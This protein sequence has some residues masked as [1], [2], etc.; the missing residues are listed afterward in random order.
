MHDDRHPHPDADNE[1]V[2]RSREGD[3][4][5]FE[6]LVRRHQA[7]MLNVA[8][9][10]T[11]VYE[12]AC[13][14]VQDAFVAAHR[15]LKGFRGAARF[16]TWMT[17]ITVNLSRNRLEQLKTRRWTEPA[18]LDD[19]ISAEDGQVSR[20]PVS[21]LPSPL[22][23]MERRSVQEK[24]RGCVEALPPDSREVLVLRDLEEFSYEEIGTILKLRDGTVKSRLSRAREA[25]KDCLKRMFREL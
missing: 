10:I 21:P 16:T 24:V 19:P 23:V 13:E 8:F 15:G 22:E 3:L 5:A 12:D 17:T 9:R 11:G 6:L 25:V 1:L 2:A 20:D 14:V 4:A 7:R 18:T